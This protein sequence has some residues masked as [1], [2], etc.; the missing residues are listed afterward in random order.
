MRAR[1]HQS[2][3]VGSLK[4]TESM[5]KRL[6]TA[7]YLIPIFAVPIAIAVGVYLITST[8]PAEMPVR[9]GE[10]AYTLSR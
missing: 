6:L 2:A 5:T 4:V 1:A 7:V 8:R 10:P 3:Y 9:V